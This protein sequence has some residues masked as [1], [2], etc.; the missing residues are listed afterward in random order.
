[1]IFTPLDEL[2]LFS[3]ATLLVALILGRGLAAGWMVTILYGGQLLTLIKMAALGYSD[4]IIHASI[5]FEI[6]G[7]SLSW[8]FDALSWF[9]ALITV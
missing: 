1:M 9:F 4:T 2:L 7:Q 5:S 8:R 3:G 6:M